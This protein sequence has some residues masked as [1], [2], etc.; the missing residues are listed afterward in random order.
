LIN[1]YLKEGKIVPVEISLG[2]I[3]KAMQKLNYNRYLIDGFPRNFDNYSGWMKYMADY[4]DIEMVIFIDCKEQELEKR[5]LNRG[6]SSGRNDDN[7][8]TA[9]KRFQTFRESTIP[10]INYFENNVSTKN[11]LLK[12][13]GDQNIE[14]V[15]SIIKNNLYDRIKIDVVNITEMLV[16]L[17]NSEDWEKYNLFCDTTR[18][19]SENEIEVFYC[20]Y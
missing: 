4:S 18:F 10:I 6:L 7:L 5:L 16:S 2:L 11:L 19:S 8:I 14:D 20:T 1:S 9:R 12:V 13:N 17:I 3:K 15:Y